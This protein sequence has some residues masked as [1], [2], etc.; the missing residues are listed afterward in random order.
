MTTPKKPPTNPNAGLAGISAGDSSISTVGLGMGLNY[1]GYD[2][3]DLA[4]HCCFE[5]VLHLLLRG[6]INIF[7]IIKDLFLLHKSF[8][9]LKP[10]FVV[11][12][13]FQKSSFKF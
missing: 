9:I 6:A 13:G 8:L 10:K 2:I 12:D 5:E 7:L 11:I 4:E 1:R 3:N